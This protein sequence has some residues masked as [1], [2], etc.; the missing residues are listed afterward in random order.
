MANQKLTVKKTAII[1]ALTIITVS[2]GLFFYFQQETEKQ[3]RDSIFELQQDNQIR[4]TKAIAENIKFDLNL[5]MAKL[6]SLS[7]SK[8][9]Q[10]GGNLSNNTYNILKHHYNQI[11][12][13]TSIDRLFLIDKSGISKM[14][15]IS[16]GQQDHRGQDFSNREWIKK[17]KD[18]LSPCFLIVLSVVMA[19]L[20]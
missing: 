8:Y 7:Y 6:Q 14:S 20:K 16:Q 18:T 17:T 10:E 4:T 12:N 3:I 5:I 11:N 19:N 13:I 1:S 15:S 9:L 2:F